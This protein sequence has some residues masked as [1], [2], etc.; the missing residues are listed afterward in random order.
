VFLKPRWIAEEGT[1]VR[2]LWRPKLFKDW[3]QRRLQR[4]N[5]R[6]WR[7]AETRT[8][9]RQIYRSSDNLNASCPKEDFDV[10]GNRGRDPFERAIHEIRREVRP[11]DIKL[12]TCRPMEEPKEG[13]VAVGQH[14]ADSRLGVVKGKDYTNSRYAK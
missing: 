12:D 8:D 5:G 9:N 10:R 1:K 2:N 6:Y 7:N 14:F 11:S 4:K 3:K 13:R